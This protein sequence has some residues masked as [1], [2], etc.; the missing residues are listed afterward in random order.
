M[1]KKS[2]MKPI[3]RFMAIHRAAPLVAGLAACSLAMP[4]AAQQ[5]PDWLD[6]GDSSRQESVE[7]AESRPTARSTPLASDSGISSADMGSQS[8]QAALLQRLMQRV[9]ELEREMQTV[10]GQLS[11]QER[12]LQRQSSRVDQALEASRSQSPPAPAGFGAA[13]GAAAV[14]PATPEPLS[15]PTMAAAPSEQGEQRA[16]DT[17]DGVVA[18]ADSAGIAGVSDEEQQRLYNEAFEVLKS[19]DYDAAIEAFQKVIDANLQGSW[20]PSAFFWQGET[21][22]VKQDYQAAAKSY[23]ELIQRYPDSGRLSD[24][25][26]KLG[27]IAQEMGDRQAARQRFNEVISDYPDSQAAGL[28]RQRLARMGDE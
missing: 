18:A 12:Q 15:T 1:T 28:A 6:W 7:S 20:A 5:A 17:A 21:Y 14:S 11:E 2:K 10:R 9:D 23:N 27:Y 3:R 4:A 19:G 26:L 24:A 22:Y 25:K 16:D 8:G 13:A